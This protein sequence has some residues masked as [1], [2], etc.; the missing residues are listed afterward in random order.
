VTVIDNSDPDWWKGKV[1]GRVG[2]F[3]SK[4]C[5]R[6]NANEKPL[7]VT[8]NLQ[9]SDSERGENLTLLRDQIV[10]QVR[11]KA[12]NS[13]SSNITLLQPLTFPKQDRRRGQRHGDDPRR[14]ARAGLLPDQVSAGGV[15]ARRGRAALRRAGQTP[16]VVHADVVVADNGQDQ[17]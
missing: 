10:I 8:H 2:Y 3:P 15:T 12:P 6:L 16:Q 13:P 5:V 1:L 11:V 7:Q 17:A 9:V 4:Y 14:R